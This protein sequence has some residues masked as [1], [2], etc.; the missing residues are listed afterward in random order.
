MQPYEPL[1]SGFFILRRSK[2]ICVDIR[3]TEKQKVR[4]NPLRRVFYFK[5]KKMQLTNLIKSPPDSRDYQYIS[6]VES[7]PRK[8]DL[9][10]Y[11]YEIEDQSTI[12]SCVSN[13]LCSALELMSKRAG[14]ICDLSR[15][16]VNYETLFLENRIGQDGVALRDALKVAN[17]TGVPLEEIWPY[18]I[19]KASTKPPK[20]AYADALS[21]MLTQYDSVPL[22]TLGSDVGYWDAINNL[23]AALA[24]GLPVVIAMSVNKTIFSLKG[25][26]PYQN[27]SLRDE[28]TLQYYPSVGNHAVT[29]VGYDDDGG[30]FIFQNSWGA[31][32]GDGGYGAIRYGVIGGAIFEA[33]VIRGFNG[34]EIAKPEPA[35][36][37]A[38]VP[39][40][41]PTPPP[42]PEP[43]KPDPA[44]EPPK[45]E[46]QPAPQPEKS[47]KTAVLIG[48]ALIAAAIATK[49]FGLW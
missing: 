4:H 42:Q 11:V 18:D 45:P 30:Y 40:P 1:S 22:S 36:S 37:P 46:P 24:E 26:L 49:V 12:G 17:K 23:K 16:F 34:I 31:G 33:W 48:V 19:S 38:P 32:W 8:V 20:E 7:L 27:Y 3:R 10:P 9:R 47:S 28:S 35:P 41:I 25:P 43:P 2:T 15:L 6:G 44:P 5:G 13:A 21:R 29:L 14:K 39:E